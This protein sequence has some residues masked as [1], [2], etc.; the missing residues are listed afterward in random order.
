[1]VQFNTQVVLS[2]QSPSAYSNLRPLP[3]AVVETV[4]SLMVTC[5]LDTINNY[6]IYV[7]EVRIN[8]TDFSLNGRYLWTMAVNFDIQS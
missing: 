5:S 4:E 3:L 1:M 6:C 8:G 2:V 7:A